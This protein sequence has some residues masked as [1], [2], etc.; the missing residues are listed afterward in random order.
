MRRNAFV[1]VCLLVL[2]ACRSEPPGQRFPVTDAC[3][4][5]S[6]YNW[7]RTTDAMLTVN[8]GAYFKI[9]FTG[10]SIKLNVD[11]SAMSGASLPAKEYPRLR[12]TI[13]DGAYTTYQLLSTDTEVTL[14]TGLAA[15]THQLTLYML[16]SYYNADRWSAPVMALKITSLTLDAGASTAAPTLRDKR[17][18]VYGDSIT[19][20]AWALAGPADLT[21]YSTAQDATAAWAAAVAD[22]LGCEYGIV[23][24]GSQGWDTPA[25]GGVPTLPD[26]WNLIYA[27]HP[28]VFTPAPDYVLCNMGANGGVAA[29]ATVTTWLTSV[30][31]AV[32]AACKIVVIVPFG[33]TGKANLTTGVTDYQ[34][35]APTDANV[36]LVDL[37]T[38]PGITAVSG[39][40]TFLATDGLHPDVAGHARLGAMTARAIAD[41]LVPSPATVAAAVW[42][43][44]DRTLTP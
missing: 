29:A 35:A 44:A 22:A 24:F 12:W 17:L 19:E 34:A 8:P 39:A 37:G 40:A 21:D 26:G 38:V 13:D 43:Y 6:P 36:V 28:R 14:A 9:G 33:Q 30:R 1:L 16:S 18:I 25:S 4:R 7:S 3:L 15:G 27:D 23:A 31:A 32:G 11:V 10:T 2:P 42:A 5:P 20:G 41:A